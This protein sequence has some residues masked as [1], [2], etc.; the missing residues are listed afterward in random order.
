MANTQSQL[1]KGKTKWWTAKHNQ[2]RR[3]NGCGLGKGGND[4]DL[5]LN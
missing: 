4:L 3:G 1:R 2:E 5:T